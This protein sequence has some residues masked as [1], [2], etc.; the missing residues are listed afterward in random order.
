[1]EQSSLDWRSYIDNLVFGIGN[2]EIK[3]LKEI[4]DRHPVNSILDVAC[5]D[6]IAAILLAGWGKDVTALDN[7]SSRIANN[8][9]KSRSAGVEVN[10]NCAD[11][12]DLSRSYKQK[13]DLVICLRDSLSRLVAEADIWGALVQM[14]LALKPG[15][16][17][18]MQTFDYD[19]IFTSHD[20]QLEDINACIQEQKAKITFQP[21][22]EKTRSS[23]IIEFPGH[24]Q[25]RRDGK[26]EKQQIPVR[27]IYQ[28]ELDLWL[29]ELGFKKFQGLEKE[30]EANLAGKVWN[31]LTIAF[32]PRPA[33]H[34]Y[35]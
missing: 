34:Q 28:K 25:C 9:S 19:H 8:N 35:D 27:P 24:C 13:C 20:Y 21:G 1:M 29:A 30:L 31:R 11:M 2:R 16:F 12:R 33:N 18:V 4:V 26:L 10:F 6:G 32:R 22:P 23:F 3:I 17:V 7:D 15:G 5:G 14:Y